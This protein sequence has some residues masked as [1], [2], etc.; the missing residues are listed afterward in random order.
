MKFIKESLMRKKRERGRGSIFIV[1]EM[2]MKGNGRR[3]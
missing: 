2:F 3:M 1:M